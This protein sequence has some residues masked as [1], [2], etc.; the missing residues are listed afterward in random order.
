[1]P[2][3]GVHVTT[4]LKKPILIKNLM[5]GSKLQNQNN[6]MDKFGIYLFTR[7]IFFGF[8]CFSNCTILHTLYIETF[9]IPI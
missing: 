1:M 8:N 6:G 7:M 5:F 3:I 9:L 2:Q 4:R